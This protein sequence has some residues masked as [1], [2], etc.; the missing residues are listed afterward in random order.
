MEYFGGDVDWL[1]GDLYGHTEN[2]GWVDGVRDW[3]GG[4][5]D[6]FGGVIGWNNVDENKSVG[7]KLFGFALGAVAGAGTGYGIPRIPLTTKAKDAWQSFGFTKPKNVG[8]IFG[9]LYIR[10]ITQVPSSLSK[11]QKEIL[12]EFNEIESNKPNPVIK[13]FFDKAKKFWKSS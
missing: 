3:L 7:D 8:N 2:M 10:V 9:D 13:S 5:R 6:W 1:G 4:D 11:R 12:E